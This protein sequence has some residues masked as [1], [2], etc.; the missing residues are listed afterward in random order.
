MKKTTIQSKKLSLRLLFAAV[1]LMGMMMVSCEREDTPTD[2]PQDTTQTTAQS[3]TYSGILNQVN[4]P[5]ETEPV[6]P[7]LVWALTV[8]SNTHILEHNGSVIWAEDPILG[9]NHS[10]GDSASYSG[11][12]QTKSDMHGEAYTVL[13]IGSSKSQEIQHSK[14]E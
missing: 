11:T 2:T 13:A 14:C 6:V 9:V 1:A 8:E 10:A 3:N 7:G 4:N 12:I 5:A